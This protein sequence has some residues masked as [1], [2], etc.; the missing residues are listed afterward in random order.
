MSCFADCSS[1]LSRLFQLMP[2]I[3]PKIFAGRF[4]STPSICSSSDPQLLLASESV[5][6]HPS[7]FRQGEGSAY[8]CVKTAGPPHPPQD[9]EAQEATPIHKSPACT[10]SVLSSLVSEKRTGCLAQVFSNLYLVSSCC[11][12][13]RKRI[14]MAPETGSMASTDQRSS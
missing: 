1:S 2:I 4:K 11:G 6:F 8:M 12:G 3:K 10:V 13:A 9:Q 5:G 7:L 14:A